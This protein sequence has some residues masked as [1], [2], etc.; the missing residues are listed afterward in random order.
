LTLRNFF[1]REINYLLFVSFENVEVTKILFD[2]FA[3][4]ELFFIEAMV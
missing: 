2:D 1:K 3:G 4:I